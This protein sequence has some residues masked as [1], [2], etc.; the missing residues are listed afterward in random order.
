MPTP[1]KKKPRRKPGPV[2]KHRNGNNSDAT[3]YPKNERQRRFCEY[4]VESWNAQGAA[5]KAGYSK[6]Y[7]HALSYQ[8][9]GKLW[10]YIQELQGQVVST[11]VVTQTRVVQELAPIA[12]SKFDDFHEIVTEGEKKI[13]RGKPYE[14]LSDEQ[15]IVIKDAWIDDDN[16]IQYELYDKESALFNIGKYLG[17]FNDRMIMERRNIDMKATFDFSDIPTEA[18]KLLE[19]ALADPE[20]AKSLQG[21]LSKYVIEGE[22]EH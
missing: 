11:A 20:D 18:L 10:K 22:G 12:F 19:Q 6:G 8:L 13:K 5:K 14:S 4:Y 17:M 9:P 16:N 2:R 21:E 3:G 15:K 1:R 7:A